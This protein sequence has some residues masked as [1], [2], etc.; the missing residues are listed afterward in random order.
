MR[1]DEAM[2]RIQEIHRIAERTTLYTLLPGVPAIVGGLLALAGC[3]ASYAMIRSF[4]FEQILSLSLEAQIGFCV[5]WTAIGVIAVAYHILWTA[6]AAR[7]QG[8][9]PVARPGRFSALALSPSIVVALILT[10]RFLSDEQV[11]YI[12][13]V[14]MM[15]YGTGVYT[16][17]LFSVRLPRLLG[18]AMLVVGAA[19]AQFTQLGLPLAA[20]SFGVLHSLFGLAV[21]RKTRRDTQS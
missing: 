18:L 3:A 5:M 8:L 6:A 4:D 17:G 10:A 20:L 2:E 1:H 14:W 16:A 7:R 21:L 12:A 9:S 15:C 11:G 13:P 19:A